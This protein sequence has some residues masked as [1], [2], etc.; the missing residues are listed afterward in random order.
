[1]KIR[2]KLTAFASVLVGNIILTFAIKLF[3]L[4]SG[5]MS[6]GTTGLA[7]VMEHL[8]GMPVSVFALI[9]NIAMLILGW[10]VW[11]SNLLLPPCSALFSIRCFWNC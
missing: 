10:V 4:P 2:K 11:V 5:L 8:T 3:L 9:F 6:N 1:M 7:L